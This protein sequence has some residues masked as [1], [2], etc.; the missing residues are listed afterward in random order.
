[1]TNLTFTISDL[2]SLNQAGN[3]DFWDA[4]EVDGVRT[5]TPDATT[6]SVPEP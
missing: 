3:N 6:S 5:G 1:M 2:D 4:I